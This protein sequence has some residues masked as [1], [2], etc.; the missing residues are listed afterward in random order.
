MAILAQAVWAREWLNPAIVKSPGLE[1]GKLGEVCNR[2]CSYLVYLI[3]GNFTRA[4]IMGAQDIFGKFD[5]RKEEFEASKRLRTECA[6]SSHTLDDIA[7][8]IAALSSNMTNYN[9]NFEE[10]GNTTVALSGQ[11]ETHEREIA[12]LQSMQDDYMTRTTSGLT[13]ATTMCEARMTSRIDDITAKMDFAM[14]KTQHELD[15]FK[16]ETTESTL[17]R[18]HEEVG[19]LKT[20]PPAWSGG[21]WQGGGEGG[22][23]GG[24][25]G[26]GLAQPAGL[27][28]K[29]ENSRDY[30]DQNL[31]VIGGLDRDSRKQIFEERLRALALQIKEQPIDIRVSR[32]RSSVGFMMFGDKQTMWRFKMAFNMKSYYMQENDMKDDG[33]NKLW[34]QISRP[35]EE[36]ERTSPM[37]KLVAIA[38]TMMT[39]QQFEDSE[40]YVNYERMVA[41]AGDKTI[42]TI[43]DGKIDFNEA[44]WTATVKLDFKKFRERY[45]A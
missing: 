40:I 32:P 15:N 45:E 43:K 19:K 8:M 22:G 39:E 13:E 44:A 2:P 34:A 28:T 36:R 9:K 10:L 18:V 26:G 31:L 38:R 3:F 33:N 20:G 35:R 5:L 11:V 7:E 42:A 6:G 21:V 4:F 27:Y 41:Y 24:G 25:G 29:H 37:R 12:R 17:K 23:G 1:S 30:L 14:K 16:K